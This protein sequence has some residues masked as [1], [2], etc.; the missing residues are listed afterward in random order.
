MQSKILFGFSIIVSIFVF[1]GVLFYNHIQ[2]NRIIE[3]GVKNVYEAGQKSKE[4]RTTEKTDLAEMQIAFD[5][6]KWIN[7]IPEMIRIEDFELNIYRHGQKQP[8]TYLIWVENDNEW[9]FI[10]EIND[11]MATASDYRASKLFLVFEKMG[12]EV[13]RLPAETLDKAESNRILTYLA[14]SNILQTDKPFTYPNTVIV[15][16]QEQ[17]KLIESFIEL[18]VRKINI[19]M[20]YSEFTKILGIPHMIIEPEGRNSEFQKFL[21]AFDPN[22]VSAGYYPEYEGY[23]NHK[24]GAEL[25]LEV[26]KNTSKII[27][28]NLYYVDSKTLGINVEDIKLHK[29]NV[30]KKQVFIHSIKDVPL[31]FRRN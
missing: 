26:E 8:E 5:E 2:Q 27:D 1:V 11:R 18:V 3:I 10:D 13:N 20:T 12:V 31:K 19:G 17:Q 30:Y 28:Y 4:Y 21:I 23:L 14:K 22:Y 9:L 29:Y 24:I 7:A 15:N 25:R 6:L 16:K